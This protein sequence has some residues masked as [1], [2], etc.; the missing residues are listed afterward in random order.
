[1]TCEY[2]GCVVGTNYE[3]DDTRCPYCNVTIYIRGM[4]GTYQGKNSSNN[5]VF[6]VHPSFSCSRCGREYRHIYSP[7]DGNNSES[8][9]DVFEELCRSSYIERKR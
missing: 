3:M 9:A 5:H 6:R 8:Y 1:M 4:I 7:C 2:C